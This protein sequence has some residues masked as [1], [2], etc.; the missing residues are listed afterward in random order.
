MN[1]F[2]KHIN[3]EDDDK[4]IRDL[5]EDFTPEEAPES[6][7]QNAM[8]RVLHD[9]A[10]KPP[11]YNSLINKNNRWWILGG[12]AAV[13]ALTFLVD[14]SVISNYLGQFKLSSELIDFSSVNESLGS[15]FSFAGQ[16]PSIIYFIGIG[17][18]ILLGMDK[19]FNRLANF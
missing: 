9:W 3:Q 5:F 6:I 13:L 12:F 15:F 14:A 2:K 8:N 10:E 18:L 11:A 16:I 7:K 19:F 17:I 4:L 1:N